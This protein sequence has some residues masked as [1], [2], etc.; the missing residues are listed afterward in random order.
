MEWT[1]SK[2]LLNLTRRQAH[3]DLTGEYTLLPADAPGWPTAGL[4]LSWQRWERDNDLIHLFLAHSG[5]DVVTPLEAMDEECPCLQPLLA[6]A[7]RKTLAAA[8]RPVP[9]SPPDPYRTSSGVLP[10]LAV[11]VRSHLAA[12]PQ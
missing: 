5:G 3:A 7:M 1:K 8:G 12:P 10:G 9:S 2:E 4:L 11:P 6:D